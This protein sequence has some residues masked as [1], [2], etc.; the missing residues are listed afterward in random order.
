MSGV[1]GEVYPKGS[2]SMT[3]FEPLAVAMIVLGVAMLIVLL[4][5]IQSDTPASPRREL[6]MQRA[7]PR[8][9]SRKTS[10]KKR[11]R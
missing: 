2:L 7:R 6:E 11:R 10:R 4:R 1:R 8:R 5:A 9:Q 3:P